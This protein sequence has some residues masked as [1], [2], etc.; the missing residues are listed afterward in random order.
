MSYA[1][2]DERGVEVLQVELPA[3]PAWLETLVPP[4]PGVPVFHD[5]VELVEEWDAGEISVVRATVHNATALSES[6]LRSVVQ[7]HYSRL[8]RLLAARRLHAWRF[9]N[10][11]PGLLEPIGE[12]VNR[13]QVFNEG[14]YQALRTWH[15][16]QP[17]F[18]AASA[19]G[20]HG[21]DLVIEVLAG[22]VAG[23]PVD[24]P[25][26][27]PP[28]RYSARWGPKP[29]CFARATR[30]GDAPLG[31]QRRGVAL[32][33]GTASV[34]DED[35]LHPGDFEAQLDETFVNL[36]VLANEVALDARAARK[37]RAPVDAHCSYRELRAYV[38]GA[39]RVDVVIGAVREHFAGVERIEIAE[40]HLCRPE[41][42][43][44]IEGLA[45]IDD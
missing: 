25:R 37:D 39:A 13:Y 16:G 29:P 40:S 24:N 30:I 45:T 43:I 12:A 10:F 3:R 17:R 2:R 15:G 22:T 44:E 4:G 7:R 19:V 34:V 8:G 23:D 5:G 32:V 42:V 31:S 28:W 18:A 1:A 36:A 14:R 35:S 11:V 21:D 26:Q 38:A 20:S 9:W 41:L 33:S 6:Q 27:R